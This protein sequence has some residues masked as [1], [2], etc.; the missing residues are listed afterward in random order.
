MIYKPSHCSPSLSTIT[1]GADTTF[2][3]C[4]LDSSNIG[5]EGYSLTVWGPDG[6]VIFPKAFT[7]TSAGAT[8]PYI[9]TVDDLKAEFPEVVADAVNTGLNGSLLRFPFVYDKDP[10]NFPVNPSGAPSYSWA[11]H[12]TVKY[13]CL[14]PCFFVETSGPTVVISDQQ[15]Y[16]TQSP[17]FMANHFVYS[18]TNWTLN[19]NQITLS[20]WGLEVSGA[21]S[22]GANFTIRF[23]AQDF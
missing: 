1:L 14:L 10:V 19:D 12:G 3:E 22:A 9:T 21:F 18:G 23:T 11:G 15:K 4:V 5:V 2:F 20:D 7:T 13:N 6:E 16:L 8:M 17:Y